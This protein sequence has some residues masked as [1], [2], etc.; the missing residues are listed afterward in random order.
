MLACLSMHP[1]F[2]GSIPVEGDGLLTAIEIRSVPFFG[3]EEKPS[4][5]WRKILWQVKEPVDA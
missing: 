3:G 2:A 1:M 5:P 4:A